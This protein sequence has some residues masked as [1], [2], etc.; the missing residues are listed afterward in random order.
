[1]RR[2]DFRILDNSFKAH[3]LQ[4]GIDRE[5]VPEQV[6]E[7]VVGACIDMN[8]RWLGKFSSQMRGISL[9]QHCVRVKAE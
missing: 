9:D 3:P 5:L 7:R 4:L 2:S 8:Q 6:C 1:M